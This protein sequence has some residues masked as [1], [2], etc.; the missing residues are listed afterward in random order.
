VLSA[1]EKTSIQAR[2]RKHDATLPAPGRPM[3]MEHECLLAFQQ[4]YEQVATP[5]EWR[6]T[7]NDLN[8]LLDRVAAHEDAL[9]AVAA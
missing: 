3:R 1:D 6:F 8:A 9:R 7:K 4:H 5:F 2:V